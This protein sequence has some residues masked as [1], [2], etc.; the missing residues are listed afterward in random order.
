MKNL[1]PIQ[2]KQPVP[3]IDSWWGDTPLGRYYIWDH[4]EWFSW[5]SQDKK[6]KNACSLDD[7]KARCSTHYADTVA[8]LFDNADPATKGTQ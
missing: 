2:W 6:L 7:A 8:S 5:A 1:K 3:F 4:G